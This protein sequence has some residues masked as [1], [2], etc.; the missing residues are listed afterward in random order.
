MRLTCL[1][2]GQQYEVELDPGA[3]DPPPGVV[4]ND[5][6]FS[7]VCGNEIPADNHRPAVVFPNARAAERS[8]SRAFQAAGLVKNVGGFAIT[9]ALLGMLFFPFGLVGAAI[10]IYCLTMIR[11]PLR[12]YSGRRLA[13]GAIVLGL[14]T[15][16]IEGTMVMRWLDDKR[17]QRLERAQH[18]ASEDLKILRRSQ[19]HFH[20]SNGTYG[21]FDELRYEPRVGWH[22][23]YLG[24]EDLMQAERDGESIGDPLPEWVVPAV[25]DTNFTAVAVAN[26]DGDDTLDVWLMTALGAPVHLSDDLTN[27]RL[28]AEKPEVKEEQVPDEADDEQGSPDDGDK[29]EDS[30][31]DKQEKIDEK[32]E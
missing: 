21:T 17:V 9:V 26:L 7:C 14:A 13:A 30:N 6:D 2:C 22:T 23:I 18:G 31:E 16:V 10:G 3:I 28:E 32:T 19:V 8:R 27:Q 15:F 11:G 12:R 25:S 29:P 20:A 24:K 1:K 4:R 5:Q